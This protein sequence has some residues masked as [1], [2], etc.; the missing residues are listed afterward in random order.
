[1]VFE[2]HAQGPAAATADLA[3]DCQKKFL[4]LWSGEMFGAEENFVLE[5]THR[6][7][8]AEIVICCLTFSAPKKSVNG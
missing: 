7:M 8:I 6:I 5:P 3:L 1:M 2:L 4:P